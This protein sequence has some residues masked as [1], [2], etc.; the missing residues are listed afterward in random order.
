[1]TF[2]TLLNP[3]TAALLGW[4]LLDQRLNRW[5]VLGAVLIL[6]SVVLGQPGTF[7][8]RRHRRSALASRV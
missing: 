8:W 2:L 7:D 1:M 5:Q 3:V 4:V 6:I